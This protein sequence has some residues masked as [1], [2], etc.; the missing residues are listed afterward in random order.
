VPLDDYHTMVWTITGNRNGR[1]QADVPRGSARVG[2]ADLAYLPNTSDWLGRWNLRA[3]LYNDFLIDRE[4][5]KSGQ[6]FS[7][8]RGIRQQDGAVTGSMGPIYDRTSEHLGTTDALIIRTRRRLLSAARELYAQRSGGV[9][10]PRSV[11]WWDGTR[12]LRKA[13]VEREEL[14]PMATLGNA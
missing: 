7:G 1:P 9:I 8:I 6:S 13:F 4:L 14:M 3:N 5:Q 10:L 12:D 2:T 11:D